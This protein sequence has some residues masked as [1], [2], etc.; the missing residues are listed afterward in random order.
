MEKV[1]LHIVI[2]ECLRNNKIYQKKLYMAFYGFAYGIAL[3][4]AGSR[5]EASL[6][7]N[8]GFYNVF[9]G[10]SDYDKTVE[11]KEWLKYNVL[12]AVTEYL[13]GIKQH[14]ST[15]YESK[16]S[17]INP[18]SNS[19]R[20]IAYDDGIKMLHQLPNCCRAVFNLFAIEGYKHDKIASML[21]ISIDVSKQLLTQARERL[22]YL[23]SFLQ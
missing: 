9:A 11:F 21:N 20:W 23:I 19:E 15:L 4:Y 1:E 18:E 10:L 14:P 8:K 2:K 6:L 5:E 12:L 22:N 7:M 13:F 17:D 16:I 3:R